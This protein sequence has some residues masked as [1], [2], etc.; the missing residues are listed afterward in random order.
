MCCSMSGPTGRGEFDPRARA[1]LAGLGEWMRLHGR[2][3]YGAGPSEFEAP[4]GLPVHTAREPPLPARVTAGRCGTST[5]TDFAGKVEYAQLLNDASEIHMIEIDPDSKVARTR[6][7]QGAAGR[8]HPRSA[9]PEAECAR[10]GDRA[11]PEV[12]NNC[13][14]GATETTNWRPSPSLDP[15][16]SLCARA[17]HVYCHSA[18]SH[19]GSSSPNRGVGAARARDGRRWRH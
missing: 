6:T 16:A 13:G 19:V 11:L 10:A 7:C 1:T 8:A 9:D 5:S 2:S 4:R 14:P 15:A 3:I 18:S 12:A 17:A